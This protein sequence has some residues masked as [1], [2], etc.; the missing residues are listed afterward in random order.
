[1]TRIAPLFIIASLFLTA[2]P[3]TNR[4]EE[5]QVEMTKA[6]LHALENDLHMW[7]LDNDGCPTL[8]QVVALGMSEGTDAWGHGIELTCNESKVEFRSAGPDGKSGTDDD[9]TRTLDQGG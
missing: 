3:A 4:Y 2:C 1:M 9:I 5:A 6:N 8:D 7:Q